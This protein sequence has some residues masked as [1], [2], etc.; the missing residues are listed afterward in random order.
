MCIL[1]VIVNKPASYQSLDWSLQ[2]KGKL[3]N[4]DFFYCAGYYGQW[5]N[6]N[7]DVYNNNTCNILN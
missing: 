7:N 1:I 6:I 5:Y 2:E 4:N 3:E